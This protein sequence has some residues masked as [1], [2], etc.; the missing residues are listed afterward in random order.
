[1]NKPALVIRNNLI[2]KYGL[3]SQRNTVR[4]INFKFRIQTRVV[5]YVQAIGIPL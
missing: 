2:V 5:R 3:A 1:M 4:D